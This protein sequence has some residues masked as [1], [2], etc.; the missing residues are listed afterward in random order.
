MQTD[1]TPMNE[2][3]M[4][5]KEILINTNQL[6]EQNKQ[7]N[8]DVDQYFVEKS[9]PSNNSFTITFLCYL[10]TVISISVTVLCIYTV[11]PLCIE[12]LDIFSKILF[13]SLGIIFTLVL[14]ILSHN[15]LIIIRDTSSKK[16]IIKVI[17]F[18]CF[19]KNKI[20]LDIE[21]THFYV[22]TEISYDSDGQKSESRYL[23]IIDDY[24]I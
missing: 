23:Y 10:I 15:K 6:E 13:I 4:N 8:I 5:S 9:S 24:K 7:K 16:V 2:T 19:A 17:N 14:L 1:I 21:N 3:P 18:L 22:K 12:N 20:V 11:T